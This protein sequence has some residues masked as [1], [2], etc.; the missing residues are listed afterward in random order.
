MID[1]GEKVSHYT[2]VSALGAGGM[3]EVYLATDTKLERQVAIKFLHPEFSKHADV[4]RR[5]V[6]EAKAASSLN[7]PNIITIHEIGEWNGSDFIAM[8]FV[9][10]QSLREMIKDSR[11]GLETTLDI[12]I[13]AA[14][15]LAA[16]HEVGIVHRDIKPEN[17][18]CRPDHLVKVLDFGLAKQ[19][20]TSGA[21]PG[22]DSQAMT[23]GLAVTEPGFA[24]GT[25]AYM[26]PEQARGKPIDARTDIWSLGVVFYEMVSGQL[27][28]PG[29]TKSDMVASILKSEPMP[30][31]IAPND[32]THS[33]EHIIK[34][35]LGKNCEE[36]YQVIKDL[37]LD[38]KILRS[39][40]KTM[41]PSAFSTLSVKSGAR[42]LTTQDGILYDTGRHQTDRRLLW[43][44]VPIFL[45]LISL[46]AFWYALVRS[47]RPEPDLFPS[48]VSTPITSWK[49]EIGEG[50]G[51]RPR[52]SPDGKLIAYVALR[53]GK[54]AIWL[55][56]IDG[57]EP[58]TRKEDDSADVSPLWSPDGGQIAYFS[59]RGGRRGIWVAPALGGN[60]TMLASLDRRGNL[61][62]WSKD[63]STIF[64]EMDQNLYTLNVTAREVS[65][66]TNLD[67]AQNIRRDFS[68]SPDE[69]QL[70]YIDRQNDRSDIWRSGLR[71][72]NP[73]RVTDDAPEDSAPIWHPDGKRIIYNSDR[74]GIKQ[75]WLAFLDGRPPAQ[76]SMSDTDSLI[77]DISKDGTKILYTTRKDD[78][79]LW[80]IST[81]GGKETQ[82]TSAIGAEY[83]PDVSPKGEAIAYQAVRRLSTGGKLLNSVLMTQGARSDAKT[84][85]L[86]T[87][88]F[89]P[90]WSP[91]GTNIA[92]LRSQSG[93]HSLW[94]T[95]ADGVNEHPVSDGG[96][97]F[98]GYS[99]LPSN[100]LQ[101]HDFQWSPD[102]RSLI[103]SALRGGVSNIWQTFLDGSGEKQLTANGSDDKKLLYFDPVF[104]PDGKNIAWSAMTSDAPD[105]RI[106][107][108]WVLS[109]GTVRELYHADSIM[110]L[111]GWSISGGRL[112]VKSVAT[113][114]DDPMPADF[115]VFELDPIDSKRLPLAALKTAYFQ[116]V[117]ISPDGKTLAFVTRSPSGDTIQTL[118]GSNAVPKTVVSSSDNRVYFLNLV[119]GPDGKT[120]YYGKQANSQVISMINNFK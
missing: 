6:R 86:A 113:K 77:S 2:I 79:D 115:D 110:R 30:L 27:P 8:E 21:A 32:L 89:Y 57:G 31:P 68:V 99:I 102:G 81:E 11:L 83:W 95:S 7:H 114:V 91:D 107:S 67:G 97:M 103:Y 45:L 17:I 62:C 98:G 35:T 84:S 52:L 61:T 16:A 54:N 9:E 44:V 118:T 25:P 37:V 50:D 26:S 34:K 33:V 55:K 101:T 106:W 56:Q 100:R 12:V 18:M 51:S 65:K 66:L 108:I 40:L 119:F 96:V 64:F 93:N 63:G 38:L 117:T 28:F 87:D 29:E 22:F 116:N 94:V 53:N 74:S 49:S 5:F 41:D 76:M 15:A 78:A 90:Q 69:K 82:L 20:N 42:P 88:G 80:S 23:R 14:S 48:L 73:I 85:Q 109:D 1:P 10:G 72:E 111:V 59:D 36:R 19:V 4:L 104:S 43:V 71:G 75:I 46:G 120:L 60:P 3:G 24:M 13:Q 70:A 105:K 58:F 92:F 47:G 39:E 112:I